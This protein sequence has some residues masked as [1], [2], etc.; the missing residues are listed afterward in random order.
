[1]EALLTYGTPAPHLQ[2]RGGDGLLEVDDTTLA[3]AL[4]ST[5][6]LPVEVTTNW[7]LLELVVPAMRADH[8]MAATY[9]T[10]VRGRLGVPLHAF[11]GRADV[12]VSIAEVEAWRLHAGN[13]FT[14]TPMA[15]GHLWDD[16]SVLGRAISNALMATPL[17]AVGTVNR[18][19]KGKNRW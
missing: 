7:E 2:R 15:S 3:D 11:V 18:P 16:T 4:V 9:R 19:N 5:S 10:A 8:Y 13:G 12:S 1:V 14:M 17:A 6:L